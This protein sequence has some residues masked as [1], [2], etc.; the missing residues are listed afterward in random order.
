MYTCPYE[1]VVCRGI[2]FSFF[3]VG[4]I[5]FYLIAESKILAAWALQRINISDG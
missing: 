4:K 3:L 1:W 2:F 5:V